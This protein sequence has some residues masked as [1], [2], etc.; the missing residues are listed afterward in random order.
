MVGVIGVEGLAG[1]DPPAVDDFLVGYAF[2]IGMTGY[3]T[4][5]FIMWLKFAE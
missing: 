5:L 4:F 3:V 2:H 1:N